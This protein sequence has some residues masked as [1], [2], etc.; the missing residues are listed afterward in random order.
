MLDMTMENLLSCDTATH[1]LKCGP[2]E[3]PYMHFK[4]KQKNIYLFFTLSLHGTQ[5]YLGRL[6]DICDL[7]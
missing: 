6:G 4:I 2:I 3:T 7:A 5:A 1:G